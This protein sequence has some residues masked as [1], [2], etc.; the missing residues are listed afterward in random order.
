M[1]ASAQ[2]SI[3]LAEFYASDEGASRL[4]P[5]IQAL[6]DAIKRGVKVCYLADAGFAKTYPQ[7][8]DD[9]SAAGAQV[10]KWD[11]RAKTGG[12]LH[13]KYFVVDK[14][15]AYLGSQN[16]DWRSLQ[17]IEELGV[18][19]S[20]PDAVAA[21]ESNFAYDWSIARGEQA[22]AFE[23]HSILSE[24]PQGLIPDENSYEL[25]KLLRLIDS[26]RKSV[27]VQ[28]LTYS[29]TPLLSEALRH[30]AARGVTVQLLVSNWEL[31]P[32]TKAAL[33]ALEVERKI[34]S[35][36]EA[37][38]GF[39]PFARVAHA[40]YCVVDGERGWVGTSNWEPDYFEKSINVGLIF[41]G[42][43]SEIPRQ[44]ERMFLRNWNSRYAKPFDEAMAPPKIG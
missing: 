4:T 34:L 9:L 21:L 42:G 10:I 33:A 41:D 7:I 6:K 37:A 16:F 20:D 1:I 38:S 39:I 5:V 27:R 22:S 36:P 31:R 15:E 19:F 35:I 8:L 28:L 25:P 32:K 18:R 14:R 2:S 11:V 26:A 30:A 24:D 23:N 40:K 3:D 44:L 17:H 12:V 43:S 13:A 29:E